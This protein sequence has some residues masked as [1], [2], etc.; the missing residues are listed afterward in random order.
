MTTQQAY[1]ALDYLGFGTAMLSISGWAM[2][3]FNLA[4]INDAIQTFVGAG[5][6]V[7]V[8]HKVMFIRQEIKGKKL[9]NRKKELEIQ[10]KE[11]EDDTED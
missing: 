8:V 10:F 3:H 7:W 11:E 2:E 9:D 6:A 1:E 4:S 5:G